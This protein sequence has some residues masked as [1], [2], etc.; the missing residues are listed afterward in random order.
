[1]SIPTKTQVGSN[2]RIKKTT[3]TK[4][5]LV[6]GSDAEAEPGAKP[7]CKPG[8]G[9]AKKVALGL[10]CQEIENV[11]IAGG[12]TGSYIKPGQKMQEEPAAA[13]GGDD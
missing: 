1:M 13:T 8:V 7:Q 10:V 3:E 9:G 11:V 12:E 4:V 5:P 2:V 6:F